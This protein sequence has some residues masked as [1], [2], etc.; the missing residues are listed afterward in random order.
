MLDV[1]G[2]LFYAGSR[3]L[4]ARLPDPGGSRSPAVVLRLR[5]R[6]TLGG[7][8]FAVVTNYAARLA[9]VGRRLF[10]SGV[11][12]D[13]ARQL[14][15]SGWLGDEELIDTIPATDILGESSL[16]AYDRA[17]AWL[18]REGGPGRR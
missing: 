12:P 15:E 5:G 8:F 17:E 6:T 18:G 11:D 14:R 10:L 9:A 1:Y 13:V 4:Q 7:T 2:S 3:T 16:L